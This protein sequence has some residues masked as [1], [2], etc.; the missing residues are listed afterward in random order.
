MILL[1][2]PTQLFA[3][4]SY[5]K[6]NN[7]KEVW[8]YEEP[9]FFT[10]FNYHKLKLLYHRIT[11]KEYA[12]WLGTKHI[13]CKYIDHNEQLP[14][15][16]LN[17]AA[18]AAIYMIDPI[19][20]ELLKKYKA[21]FKT[22]IILPTQHFTL[23]PDEIKNNS[24]I[25]CKK[26]RYSNNGG[27]TSDNLKFSHQQFYKW[28]RTRLNLL[29]KGKQPEG[30]KWT[31]DTLNRSPLPRNEVLPVFKKNNKIGTSTNIYDE[32]LKYVNKY[33]AKNYG[34]LNL[35]YP[36]THKT[37]KKWLLNFVQRRLKK[38]GI[39][40]DASR[41]G[42]AFIYHS[43]LTPMLNI[44][45]LT[46]WDIIECVMTNRRG[47]SLSSL[48]GFIRQLIGWRNYMY[49]IYILYPS[50]N[51]NN[52][53]GATNKLDIHKWWNGNTGIYPIDD[54]IKNKIV[55]YAYTHHIE[56]LMYLGAIMM[57]AN[58]RPDDVYKIFMEWTIDAYEWVMMPNIYGM[59]QFAD[60][61]AV[62][63]RPY[64]SASAYILRM[65]DYPRGDWTKVW[66]ALYYSFLIRHKKIFE[67]SYVYGGQ[68]RYILNKSAK[69]IAE[70]KNL[71]ALT[72]RNLT[73][74]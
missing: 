4:I 10:A 28:Q 67:R 46:D 27:T 19:D 7:I 45:L 74:K 55:K 59:S 42:E 50:I 29:M 12:K 49:C 37:A 68:V 48:E 60:G 36:T 23:Q 40:E 31:F 6:K 20:H 61:G 35:I 39:Y 11:C 22:L 54:I 30:G 2:L 65:S 57:M 8:L 71:A 33:F 64:C 73:K 62:M 66:T 53:F 5:I 16:N 25:F 43:V 69:E 41:K 24:H 15:I 72:I 17:K 44:G 52:Y 38:F 51:K 9:K 14:S 56:R 1:L 58:V 34:E 3:D 13:R 63:S 26:S 21:K 32:A 18:D 47:I 70:T